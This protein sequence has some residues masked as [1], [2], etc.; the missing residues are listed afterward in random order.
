[1][2]T[3]GMLFDWATLPM[4]IMWPIMA[5]LYTRLAKKEEADMTAEF[6]QQYAEYMQRTGQFLPAFRRAPVA[7]P[8]RR[9]VKALKTSESGGKNPA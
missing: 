9:F 4:L 7:G 3:L 2:I 5:V 6:G 8:R 1:M